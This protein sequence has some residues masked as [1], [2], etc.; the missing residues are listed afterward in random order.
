[1]PGKVDRIQD[2]TLR[3]S[4]AEAHDALRSGDYATVVRHAS[5]AYLELLRRNPELPQGQAALRSILF[6]PR[7]G[8][9]LIQDSQGRPELIYDRD[10]FIFSEAATYFEFAVDSL[11]KHGL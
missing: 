5:G 8:V 2:E 9:R 1:M 7:L 11:V 10:K 4:L 6:F 3:K